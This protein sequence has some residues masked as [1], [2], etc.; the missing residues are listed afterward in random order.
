MVYPTGQ[1]HQ[2]WHLSLTGVVLPDELARLLSRYHDPRVV[3][4]MDYKLN[5]ILMIA[6]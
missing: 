1:T 4:R 2:L 5:D 3:N 6:R